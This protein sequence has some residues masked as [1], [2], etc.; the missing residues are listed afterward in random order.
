MVECKYIA[1]QIH[2]FVIMSLCCLC[3]TYYACV[4]DYGFIEIILYYF[5]SEMPF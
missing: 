2:E 5:S 4:G 1:L 3:C